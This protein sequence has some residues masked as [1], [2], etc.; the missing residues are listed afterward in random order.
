M[1]ATDPDGLWRGRRRSSAHGGSARP[2][3]TP[4][5]GPV[6][7]AGRAGARHLTKL[8]GGPLRARVILVLACVLGLASA[9]TATVGA[10][11]IEL[12]AG[13]HISNADIGL[14]VAVG[15]LA[16]AVASIPFGMVADRLRRTTTLGV[17]VLLWGS[18]MILSATASTFGGL[19]FWR[20]WLGVVTAAAGPAIASLV[21]DYFASAERGR[22]YSYIL[23]GELVG[24]G[25]GFVITG[26]I[27][28]LSW[29]VAFVLLGLA[30]VPLAWALF[31]LPEPVRGGGGVL[32]ADEMPTTAMTPAIDTPPTA[33][34]P[35]SDTQITDAQRLAAERAIA[36]DPRLLRHGTRRRIGLVNAVRYVLGVRTNV[37]LIL[38]SACGYYFL[39]GVQT[40]GVEFVRKQYHV[41]AA[42]ANLLMLAIGAGAALGVITAGPLSDA[43]L[44]HGRLRAR[45]L[46]AAVAATGTVLLFVPALLTRSL[47]T[48]LPYA[49]VAAALLSAQNPPIDA[50]RLDIMPPALWGRAEGIRTLLRTMAQ[51]LAP[52]LFGVMS[53]YVTLQTTFLVM[54]VPLA[55]SAYFLVRAMRTY[56][57]DVATAAAVAAW[58]P[59]PS[60]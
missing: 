48:A 12:R 2:A 50:A 31:L 38:S 16:G 54:L 59:R 56:P 58:A 17:A 36:P 35:S 34:E 4:P 42:L 46:V 6:V 21:G 14:L 45:V 23:T 11:A 29:R 1:S 22:I 10:S 30:A 51:A 40:F 13:L 49:I 25:A 32:V 24:A 44:R 5:R 20:L 7:R 53:D 28:T 19:L 37:A 57:V 47:L 52:L 18:A 39:A 15:A 26:D 33:A 41:N 3:W 8:V 27:A 43:W 9:D 60:T 55:A